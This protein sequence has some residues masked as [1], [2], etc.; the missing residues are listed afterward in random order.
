[1]PD[2]KLTGRGGPGR[3]Q[4]RP[5]KD[6]G[7]KYKLISAAFPPWVLAWLAENTD[8]RN[9]FIVQAVIKAIEESKP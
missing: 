1:M 3:G 8:N 6:L 2:K 5:R 4:G 7:E 9:D